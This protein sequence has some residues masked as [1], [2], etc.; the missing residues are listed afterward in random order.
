MQ[1]NPLFPD[2]RSAMDWA[3][4]AMPM[5][6]RGEHAVWPFIRVSRRG[7]VTIIGMYTHQG[8]LPRHLPVICRAGI[9]TSPSVSAIAHRFGHQ[10]WEAELIPETIQHLR[11]VAIPLHMRFA[12]FRDRRTHYQPRLF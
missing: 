6:T 11:Y 10:C 8:L 7:M 5:W 4:S 12:D 2:V 1:S 9:G 3:S